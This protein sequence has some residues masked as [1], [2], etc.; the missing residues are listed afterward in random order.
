MKAD[1]LIQITDDLKLLD[2]SL[3]IKGVFYDWSNNNVNVIIQFREKENGVFIHERTFTFK[4]LTGEELTTNDIMN[5][6]K[7]H[8]ILSKFK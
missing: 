8:P 6:L 3:S 2:P 1:G 7:S 5:L 4:N